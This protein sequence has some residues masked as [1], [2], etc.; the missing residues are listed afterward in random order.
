M[1]NKRPLP[2][3]LKYN[4]CG[5]KPNKVWLLAFFVM[6]IFCA[7]NFYSQ[8]GPFDLEG[9]SNERIIRD[10]LIAP[11]ALEFL[12]DG[13]LLVV[14]KGG[15][16]LIADPNTG[17]KS[18]YLDISN[19]VNS[20]LERGLLDIAVPPDFDPDASSGKNQI[21]MFYTRSSNTDRAVIA[22]FNHIEGSGGLASTADVNSELILWTDTDAFV[23]CCHYGG[24]LDF[25]PDGKIW[26]T[27]A[28]KF[29]TSNSNE[30]GPDDNWPLNVENTSGKII[31]I[32][33]DGT[34]PDGTDGWPANPYVDG[35]VDGPYPDT[36]DF[37]FGPSFDPHP[38]IWAYGLR[39]PF[40]AEWDNEY[41]YFYIGEV[42]GNQGP[43][44]D[45]IHL[46][47]LNQPGVFYGWNFY[48]GVSNFEP[49]GAINNFQPEDFP[50]P[51]M[52][53]A[54]PSNDDYFSAPIFDI[55]HS[56][57]T[58]G[59]VYR[60]NM[61]PNEFDGVYFYGNYETNYIRYLVLDAT[62][63]MVQG[64]FEFKPSAEIPGNAG[65]IIFLEE[66]IDGALYYIN[67]TA[68]GGQVQRIV[69]EGERPPVLD[70]FTADVTEGDAPLLVSFSAE[71]SDVDTALESLSFTLNFGDGTTAE[72]GNVDSS[73]SISETHQYMTEGSYDA[74][75]SVTD[76]DNTPALSQPI[77]IT[78]GDPN[79]PPQFVSVSANPSFGDP[80]LSVLFSA[81]VIDTDIDDP[82]T[83]LD[84]V[85]DFGD[86]SPNATGNPDINGNIS[87]THTYNT[88]NTS[89]PYNAI[90]SIS[91]GEAPA[92]FS[93]NLPIQVGESSALPVSDNLVFQVESFIKV[94]AIGS[95]VTE[96]LDES[97][98]GNNL[99]ALGDPQLVE[100]ATPTGLPAIVLDGDG[101]FLFRN[102][103]ADTA[104]SGFPIGN[105]PRTVFFVVDYETVTNNE[106]AGLVY[107]SSSDNQAFG[108]TL[109]G[110]ENDLALQGWG[111]QHNRNTDIDG[112]IDPNTG[113]QRGFI[114]HAVVFDGSNFQ[115]YLNGVLIDSGPKTYNTVLDK[116]WIGQNLNGG[117]TP[118]S[119][120]A[121][122][123]YSKALDASEFTAVE[124]YVQTT[125]LNQNTNEQP[126]ANDDNF[127]ATTGVELFIP[128]STGLL[129][130]DI[131]D[132]ILTVTEINGQA[133]ANGPFT[134]GNGGIL[135]ADANGSITYT[136]AAGFSGMESFTYI[137]SDGTLTDGAT[138]MITV[139][140]TSIDEFPVTDGLVARLESD[141]NVLRENGVVTEWLSTAG[142]NMDL[143]AAGNPTLVANATPTGE[144]AISLDGSGD[145]LE[146]TAPSPELPDGDGPRSVYF[147]VDYKDIQTSTGLS[148]G[149]DTNNQA[150]GV[151]I[152]DNTGLLAIQGWGGGND[153][154]ST[155]DGIGNNDGS[156]G[157]DWF[158]HSVR[159]DGATVKHYKDDQ[160]IDEVVKGDYNT[161]FSRFVIGE[162]ISGTG[163]GEELDVAAAL[164]YDREVTEAEHAQILQYLI[165]KYLST[166][167]VGTI[168][169]EDFEDLSNG[170]VVDNG[171]T[172]WTSSRD[173][174]TFEVLDGWFWTN[175]S[176]G[177]G[178]WTSEVIP[179]GGTVSLS[180]D[181]DDSD[182][183]KERAD[184]VRA[185][186]ILD[187]GTPVE[188]GFVNND[189][190]PQ[191]LISGEITGSTVQ[192]VVE[193]L[194]SGGNENYFIDNVTVTG[195]T[196]GGTTYALTVNN[197]SGDGSYESGEVVNIVADAAPAGQQFVSWTGDVSGIADPNGPS[198]TV[199]MPSSDVEVTATYGPID[200]TTYAL[201]VNSGSGD[202]T[203]A[204]GDVVNIVA[205]AAP[206]GQQFVSWT[207]DVSGVA[208]T[209]SPS[210]TVTIPSSDVEVTATYG[211]V[212]PGGTIWLEDFEDLSNGDVV[213][214]GSTAWSS[215]RDGGTFEVLDGRFWTNVSGGVG[216]W[217]SEVIPISGTVS[218]SLDVDDS[219]DNKERADFVRALY[220]LDGGTP[221]EFGFVNN[222]I[223]PQT[224]VSG[225]LTGSTV[226]I[227]VE[228]LVSGGNENYFI[229]NVTVTGATTGGTTYALTVNSGSG[230][231]SY[232]AG[233]VVNIVADAAP[234]GQQFVSWTGDVSGVDDT[235]S[236]STTVTMP[237]S[238]VEVTATYGE[239][240]PGGTIWLEDFEDLS[241]GDVVDNGATAW[242][243]SRTG[244]IFEV[245]DGRFWTNVSGGVGTWTSE[246]I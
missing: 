234:A 60:G 121:A 190:D 193:S 196:T 3:S 143:V 18:T 208:D 58:G 8:T 242:S 136:S 78:V 239:V 147:V 200:I 11:L 129:F 29:N 87:V 225:D 24:G 35:I 141:S 217:T 104:L 82:V 5:S 156:T 39:N 241:N 194:V 37:D 55:P 219:D 246:V 186:Y 71:V 14:E 101:D 36:T 57:L 191:T 15:K 184:F 146:R 244:G 22:Q 1:K 128:Q 43:S 13:R 17:N 47:S 176:G 95:T 106:F 181:V 65:N 140:T 204:A 124:N 223:D 62:G 202:G 74:V 211:E 164:V 158:V 237:S 137:V 212:S 83:S 33:R 207:G 64:D 92:V 216:T 226:Q 48:E 187:G 201:T 197:G 161:T 127:T 144:A 97:G 19:I 76:G 96:W 145:W 9:F 42:G 173:G 112:V 56:S 235:N 89:G 68:L 86:G 150:F 40:R 66:G 163:N 195:A 162:E 205:N 123:I 63:T 230:D 206:V 28:D 113:L 142:T 227:V 188:F 54:D 21:Y 38:S 182:D 53:L 115:H 6:S 23:G 44:T 91:D 70:A 148:F 149:T 228:S 183:N 238:D 49:T 110:N 52:D 218:L 41:G 20:G 210:T 151:V 215:S 189:I 213:D 26:L 126:I 69:F 177:V 27:S 10:G 81:T 169:L 139:N 72:T 203:Y 174:G 159:Y 51:D 90:F 59:F 240:S 30:G 170:D 231:G 67:Y 154:P 125:F 94:G 50:Q 171:A 116:L 99:L 224:F 31:R 167:A 98:Q 103:S 166:Q 133:I 108:L 122:F 135:Q 220:I 79:D 232:V 118:I 93:N 155:E 222:D 75:L 84:Y 102:D 132:G 245:L 168:W 2:K 120:A 214:N 73:G 85:L 236:P 107:G 199:T 178:T 152:N 198:T 134:L 221:V 131:D 179:I 32:N 61:F 243:S 209:N 100:N 88:A 7:Q 172:A 114:S 153:L 119:V 185:L 109:D 165:N 77:L 138:V 229:D 45:D 46:A 34:I 105:Q 157:D 4:P 160:L 80:P 16:I 111:E 175:V 180:L 12:P 130:N 117:F 192:I 25:G 233:D